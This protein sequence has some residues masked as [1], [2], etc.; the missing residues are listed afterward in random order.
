MAPDQP[1]SKWIT[2]DALPGPVGGASV[3]LPVGSSVW[4][5]AVTLSSNN[6]GAHMA[7]VKRLTLGLSALE[8]GDFASLRNKESLGKARS[9]PQPIEQQSMV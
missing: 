5:H 8:R 3:V 2:S 7:R 9:K 1:C 6:A 4:R